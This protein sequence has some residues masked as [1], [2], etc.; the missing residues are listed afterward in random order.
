[1][2]LCVAGGTASNQML[3]GVDRWER[4][5]DVYT[6]RKELG[7]LIAT[8]ERQRGVRWSLSRLRLSLWVENICLTPFLIIARERGDGQTYDF[9]EEVETM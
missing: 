8:E 2:V 9:T 3:K 6:G 7:G 1:M 4:Q 5:R